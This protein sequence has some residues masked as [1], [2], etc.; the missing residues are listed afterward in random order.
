MHVF[1]G[2]TIRSEDNTMFFASLIEP[3]SNTTSFNMWGGIGYT[4][5][6]TNKDM[7]CFSSKNGD[8]FDALSLIAAAPYKDIA[9]NIEAK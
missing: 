3:E 7:F 6:H 5:D 8:N 2:G 4:N 9:G 1:Y